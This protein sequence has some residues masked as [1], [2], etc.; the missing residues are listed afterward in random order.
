MTEQKQPH[1]CECAHR[2]VPH[3]CCG[4]H[5]KMGTDVVTDSDVYSLQYQIEMPPQADEGAVENR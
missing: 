2:N 4:K 5:K 1:A 3:K